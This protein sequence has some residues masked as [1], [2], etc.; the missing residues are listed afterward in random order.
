M[1]YNNDWLFNKTK[2]MNKR[3]IIILIVVSLTLVVGGFFVFQNSDEVV[4]QSDTSETSQQNNAQNKSE[5]VSV[6]TENSDN[7]EETT[8]KQPN[9]PTQTVENPPIVYTGF[10]HSSSNPL[11]EGQQTSTT[12]T[13]VAGVEC[14]IT[15][16]DGDNVITFDSMTTDSQGIALWDWIGGQDVTSG[17]WNVTA[18]AGGKTSTT[19][20]IYVQ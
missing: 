6:E 4:E 5:D 15:F 14:A 2:T 20:V 17:T 12:C 16:T 8:T 3:N 13:S 9:T 1:Y 10:G 7:S 18:T 11:K 19:E